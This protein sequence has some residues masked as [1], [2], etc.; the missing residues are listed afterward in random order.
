MVILVNRLFSI[1]VLL[2]KLMI[3]GE[4]M[5]IRLGIIIFW[6]EVLVEIFIYL[7]YLVLL[8]V[9]LKVVLL[10]VF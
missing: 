1:L 7:L 6:I 2:V 5:V 8:L 3:I 10:F 9:V 4:I